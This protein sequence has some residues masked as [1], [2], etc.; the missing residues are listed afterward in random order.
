[1]FIQMNESSY[2]MEMDYFEPTGA[3]DLLVHFV[4]DKSMLL[5]FD[6]LFH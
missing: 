6:A 3:D 4:I 1:M 5:I 2:S